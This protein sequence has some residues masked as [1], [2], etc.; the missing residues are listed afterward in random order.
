M[1]AKHTDYSQISLQPS[2][3]DGVLL[4]WKA[5]RIPAHWVQHVK[6]QH[7]L[8]ARHDV[9][10]GVALWVA[11]MQARTTVYVCVCILCACMCVFCVRVCVCVCVCV[12]VACECILLWYA[13]VLWRVMAE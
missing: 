7:T 5:E 12:C 6:A 3:L 13:S 4:S 8:V 10:G 1:R 9:G 2:H 11:H